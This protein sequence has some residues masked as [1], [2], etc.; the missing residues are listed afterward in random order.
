MTMKRFT[1][2]LPSLKHKPPVKYHCFVDTESNW[3]QIEG[4][5][6][7]TKH[8]LR[9]GYAEFTMWNGKELIV[10]SDC[11][12]TNSDEFWQWLDK[13][14]SDKQVWVWAHNL[15]F[16]GTLIKLWHVLQ[17]KN[18]NLIHFTDADLPAFFQCQINGKSYRFL[19]SL[20]MFRQSLSSIGEE[21]GLKKMEMPEQEDGMERWLPYCKRD[22]EILRRIISDWIGFI[23]KHELGRLCPSLASQ[24]LCAYRT[25]FMINPIQ[26]HCSKT[27]TPL[28]RESY[29]GG[30]VEPKF[31][32]KVPKGTV[33]EFDINSLYPYVMKKEQYPNLLLGHE[34]YVSNK[35]IRELMEKYYVIAYVGID[36]TLGVFPVRHNGR[37]MFPLGKYY[38]A[39]HH[40]ELERAL[41]L[42]AISEA[43]IIAYYNKVDLFS[44][45]VDFFYDR[46]QEYKKNGFGT[47]EYMCK[48]F[49]NSLYGKFGQKR[50]QWEKYTPELLKKMEYDGVLLEGS[51]NMLK[52][53]IE[54]YQQGELRFEHAENGKTYAARRLLGQGQ[55]LIGEDES[56]W[57]FPAIAGAVTAY[58]REYV[59]NIQTM[60]GKRNLFYTDTDSFFVNA[61]GK[62]ILSDNGMLNESKLGKLKAK[63]VSEMM[64][65]H[66]PK[67]YETEHEVKRKGIRSRAKEVKPGVFNQEQWPGFK[68][69]AKQGFPHDV[70]VKLITKCL[71]RQILTMNVSKEGWT[72]PL[73]LM[74]HNYVQHG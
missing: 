31:I 35:R 45:Y 24:A 6:Q 57:S 68:G 9:F 47:F 62:K 54:Q 60:I 3:S 2:L 48:I 42:C 10:K 72:Y 5:T 53:Y 22:V 51:L 15:A 59:R 70:S 67:D 63:T 29:Y 40:V 52:D 21:L 56:P 7:I 18:T 19:D 61:K 34:R 12:F 14:R 38:T 36:T 58:A 74:L 69:L 37:L 11:T 16:D 27:I 65:I 71:K 55:L 1:Q 46:R 25:K 43:P 73:Y 32:G 20:N 28:E 39:L 64:I 44:A 41:S 66:G 8:T 17:E 4:K 50:P 30:I 33:Y 23:T 26:L 13:Q 49:L